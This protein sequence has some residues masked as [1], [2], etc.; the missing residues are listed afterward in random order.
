MS[1]VS[2]PSA[3]ALSNGNYWNSPSEINFFP[4]ISFD[5]FIDKGGLNKWLGHIQTNGFV[6]VSDTPASADATKQ[7]MERVAYVRNEVFAVPEHHE[8][9]SRQYEVQL[10]AM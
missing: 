1:K 7:L 8:H 10:K 4:E 3:Q 5:E 9:R 6:L 2:S